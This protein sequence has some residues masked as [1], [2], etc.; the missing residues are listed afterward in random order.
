MKRHSILILISLLFGAVQAQH[1]QYVANFSQFQQ[2]MGP[3]LTGYMGSSVEGLYRDRWEGRKEAPRTF[4]VSG[5]FNLADVYPTAES[6]KVQHAFGVLG[7]YDTYGATSTQLAGISYNA[8][9]AIREDW[10]VR[11]GTT[12]TYNGTQIDDSD[13]VFDADENLVSL[14]T[15]ANRYSA[16]LGVAITGTDAYLGYT[17]ANALGTGDEQSGIDTKQHIVQ[18]GYRRTIVGP[19]GLIANGMYRYDDMQQ[20]VWE[21]QVKASLWNTFW[22]GGGYRDQLAY[23]VLA[24]VR[25]KQFTVGYSREIAHKNIRGFYK[26]N[27]EIMLRYNLTQ[28]YA[29]GSKALSIW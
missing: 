21:A 20:G 19:L 17:L 23:T 7:S 26:G 4:L 16:A 15:R 1:R 25:I 6:G 22:V 13:L 3:A 12:L 14:N 10:S 5:Q 24:G 28:V 8:G 29:F 11:V 27:N 9:T 2:Y 18:A